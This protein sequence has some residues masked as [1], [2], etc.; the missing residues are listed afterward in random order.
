MNATQLPALGALALALFHA[1]R[2]HAWRTA[3]ARLEKRPA[4]VD[5]GDVPITV[6]V[7]VR[8]G[9]STLVP[10]LQDLYAQSH[11]EVMDVVVVDDHST[12]GTAALVERMALRWPGL[13]LVRLTEGAGKKAA[14]MAGVRA[15]RH[16]LLLF[17]DADVRCGPERV[18]S[19]AAHWEV[20]RWHL[21]VAPVRTYGD[22][23]LGLL[24]EEEQAALFGAAVGT[25]SEGTPMLAYGANLAVTREAFEAVGG[26]GGDRWASGDDVFL[27]ERMRRAG[28]KVALL[29]DPAVIVATPGVTSWRAFVSQRLRWAGKMRG[30]KALGGTLGALVSLLLPWLLVLATVHMARH[31]RFGQGL[32]FAVLMLC[33]AW[34]AWAFPTVGASGDARTLLCGRRAPWRTTL[35]LV[36]FSLYAPVIALASLV[37]R[38]RWKGRRV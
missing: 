36:C 35:A 29:A 13:R 18:R 2:M 4:Q 30:V 6:V 10:L 24:Q 14:L 9:E 8:D 26:H 22:G 3:L 33:V 23:L 21:L 28:R 25:W 34:C 11:R 32:L 15:A 16:Q 5:A 37:V 1:A 31:A 7:P 27:L 20:H 38:P 19:V 12:D 17:T